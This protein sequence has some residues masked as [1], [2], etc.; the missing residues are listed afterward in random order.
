MALFN[1]SDTSPPEI[2][3]EQRDGYQQVGGR[4]T[5]TLSRLDKREMDDNHASSPMVTYN[6]ILN[7]PPPPR[8]P[9]L[10]MLVN[11]KIQHTGMKGEIQRF[12]IGIPAHYQPHIRNW[13]R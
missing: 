4:T 12:P 2:Y 6:F 10:S 1:S 8:K 7:P 11:Q 3:Q 13:W 9:Y 5:E